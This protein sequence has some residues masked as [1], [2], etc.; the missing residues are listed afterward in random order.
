MKNK[1]NLSLIA[2]FGA[3]LSCMKLKF[4]TKGHVKDIEIDGGAAMN[5]LIVTYMWVQMG[6]PTGVC[7]VRSQMLT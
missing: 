4:E 5:S 6:L 2:L 1:F 7:G 3:W